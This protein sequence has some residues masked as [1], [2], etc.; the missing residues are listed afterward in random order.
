MPAPS[1]GLMPY[2]HGGA[3]FEVLIAHPG[4]PFW[5]NKDRGAWSVV[6]GVGEPGET[7]MEAARREFSE[8][9]GWPA[10]DGEWLPLGE[11]VLRSGKGIVAWAVEADFDP[12]TLQPGT[13]EMEW[14][15]RLM[16]FPEV[17][18]VEWFDPVTAIE[19]LNDAQGIFVERLAAI[20]PT[21][22]P[23][24]KGEAS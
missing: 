1:A 16:T 7:E 22:R 2:R 6:K 8:E 21:R 23:A 3:T 5:A 13:C 11:T 20:V 14:R 19:R 17:D 4:G 12:D 18:R 24:S 9:T 15:G 10:P